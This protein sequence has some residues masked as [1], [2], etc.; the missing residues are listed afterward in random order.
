MTDHHL[1]IRTCESVQRYLALGNEWFEAH[2]ATFVRNRSTPRRYDANHVGLMR[3]GDPASLDALLDRAESE[4]VGISHRRFDIDALTP[5]EAEARLE[6]EGSFSYV[7]RVCICS[8]RLA[9]R[10]ARRR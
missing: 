10:P 6:F 8:S 2:G 1:V 9:C 5:P 3:S 7:T 4:F